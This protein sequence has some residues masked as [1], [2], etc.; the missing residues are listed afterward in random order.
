MR[1]FC[2]VLWSFLIVFPCYAYMETGETE[3]ITA[4][5]RNTNMY[6]L[7]STNSLEIKRLKQI[8]DVL[9]KLPNSELYT[10]HVQIEDLLQ[11]SEKDSVKRELNDLLAK[12]INLTKDIKDLFVN[13]SEGY[14]QIRNIKDSA[15][16][17]IQVLNELN[18]DQKGGEI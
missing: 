6:R 1:L 5:E 9:E 12:A 7:N 14:Q 10:N 8:D 2:L 16:K 3:D 4:G 17:D 18:F 15:I 11:D 13:N